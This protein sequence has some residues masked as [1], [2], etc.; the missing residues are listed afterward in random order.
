M[1]LKHLTLFAVLSLIIASCC[2]KNDEIITTDA[3]LL[4]TGEVALDGCGFLVEIDGTQYKPENEEIIPVAFQANDTTLVKV[5]YDE[6]IKE[7]AFTCGLGGQAYGV[8]H[9]YS[10]EER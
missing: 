6:N 10:I 5:E 8:L 4:W 7:I 1:K 9:L 3:L 2:K